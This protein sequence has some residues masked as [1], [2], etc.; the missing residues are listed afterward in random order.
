[1]QRLLIAVLCVLGLVIANA[2][3]AQA[4]QGSEDAAIAAIVKLGGRVTFKRET[5]TY[6]VLMEGAAFT[7]ESLAHLRKL[8]EVASLRLVK[9]SISDEGLEQLKELNLRHLEYTRARGPG[10]LT[11]QGLAHVGA[12]TQLESLELPDSD[13]SDAGVKHLEG[14]TNLRSL[15]LWR[16]RITDAGLE[17]FKGLTKLENL[18]IYEAAITDAGLEHLRSLKNLRTLELKRTDVT[19]EGVKKLRGALPN[20]EISHT[21]RRR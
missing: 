12:L 8:G 11:D 4:T 3:G 9:T 20:C 2:W 5:Q 21:P 15:V 14:L 18:D 16:T 13:V 19:E 10:R 1:M 17:H 6:R 7:N